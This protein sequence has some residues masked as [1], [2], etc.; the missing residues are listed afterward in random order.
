L[1]Y[2]REDGVCKAMPTYRIAV[3]TDHLI[4]VYRGER[5]VDKI[6]LGFDSRCRISIRVTF[7]KGYCPGF[8][9]G[10]YVYEQ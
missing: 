4:P 5:N 7:N 10:N 1:A 2:L 3:I 6:G 9:F 8:N